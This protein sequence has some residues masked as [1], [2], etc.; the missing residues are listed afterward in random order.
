MA[1]GPEGERREEIQ[2]ADRLHLDRRHRH[3]SLERLHRGLGF[4]SQSADGR[5]L[6]AAGQV[7]RLSPSMTE[8][9]KKKQW[10]VVHVL[11]GQENKV[12]ENLKKRVKTE[13]MGDFVYE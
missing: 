5:P 3:A 4:S 2:G 11:A 6:Q 9:Q 8:E 7:T 10:Y 12:C 13:E 1:L